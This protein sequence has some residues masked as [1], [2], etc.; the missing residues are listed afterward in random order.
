MKCRTCKVKIP[1]QNGSNFFGQVGVNGV[2]CETCA[3]D[4]YKRKN[5]LWNMPLLKKPALVTMV[6]A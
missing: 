6:G 3:V 2:Q 5:P 1:G 4:E